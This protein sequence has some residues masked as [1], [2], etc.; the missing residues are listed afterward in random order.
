MRG[1]W[2]SCLLF[3]GGLGAG[4]RLVNSFGRREPESVG[5]VTGELLT[6]TFSDMSINN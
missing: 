6:E 5:C 4:P 2:E 3:A 1:K